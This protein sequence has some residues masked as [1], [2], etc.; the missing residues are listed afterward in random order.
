MPPRFAAPLLTA[1]YQ[2][3]R[4]Y[5]TGATG[6]H[7]HNAPMALDDRDYMRDSARRIVDRDYYGRRPRGQDKTPPDRAALYWLL[8]ALA[9]FVAVALLW[10][11]ELSR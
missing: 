4:A 3:K 5:L 6:R 9:V 10:L 11:P 2:E 8:A 7:G 1:V